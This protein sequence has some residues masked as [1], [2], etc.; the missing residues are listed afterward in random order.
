M[1]NL[2]DSLKYQQWRR[3]LHKNNIQ[4]NGLEEL[5]LVR[6]RGGEVLFALL[7]MAAQAP[8]GEPLLP[9][10]LLR[11]HFVGVLTCL[12]DKATGEERFLMVRQRRVG[13]G[14][15]MLEHPAGMVDNTKDPYAVAI[16]EVE[17]ETG[18]KIT[19]DQ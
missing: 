17:E 2:G 12:K 8:N 15:V 13:T 10:V 11:G 4:L 18:L 7:R 9:V 1:E 3:Q 19:R 5:H 14:A 16:T 6:K